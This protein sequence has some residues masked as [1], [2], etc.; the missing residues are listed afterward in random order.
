M[1]TDEWLDFPELV[2][3]VQEY[4]EIGLYD[5]AISLL[6]RYT[7]FFKDEWEIPFL[8]SRIY[9]EQN[10]PEKAI[11]YLKQSLEIEPN[12]PDSLLGLFYAY[13]QMSNLKEA[14][15][16]LGEAEKQQPTHELVLNA[17]IWYYTEICDFEKALN[18]FKK[19]RTALE[20][21]PEVL[22]NA[23]IA[24]ERFGAYDDARVCFEK[25]MAI[26]PQF[27]EV[28]DLLADQFLFH[29]SPEESIK[30]YKEYL[31]KSPNNIRALS[32]LT[33]CFSQ[34]NQVAEAE[35]TAR[36]TIRLYPN[37]PTGYVDLGYVFLNGEKPDQ[38][39]ASAEKALDVSPLD[40]EA[41]RLK[42]LAYSDLGKNDEATTS[43]ES[44][45]S[46]DPENPEIMRDYYH[47][48][49][50]A[51]DY[52][53]MNTLV[54]EVIRLERPYCMEDYWFLADYYRE[55]QKNVLS[56]SYLR[57][58]YESTPGEKEILPPMAE[59][60]ADT[61][62]VLYAIPI[63]KSYIDSRGWNDMCENIALHKNFKTAAYR[64][65]LMFLKFIGQSPAQFRVDSF[66]KQ[67]RSFGILLGIIGIFLCT[68]LILAIYI[69]ILPI[70]LLTALPTFLV[71]GLFGAGI[72]PYLRNQSVTS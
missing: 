67:L 22:R 55:I 12:N 2:E 53:K 64:Q 43:F 71:T 1:S 68:L 30:L 44:A 33:Y 24:F 37:S 35:A 9:T 11:E 31:E 60:L 20:R 38:T 13:T 61:G 26:S 6:N 58:A 65:S 42:A 47:H 69:P 46:L 34:N 8:F 63:L 56:F 57:L 17:L 18:Y 54:N 66:K 19:H 16:Y 51:G 28:R 10:K 70:I 29:G 4:I 45:L 14:A 49:R 5:E 39:L 41:I 27:E 50:E 25:A 7:S 23:G 62:H 3:K 59:T 52:E 15:K 36:E 40:S 72:R 32:R 48:L 21:N